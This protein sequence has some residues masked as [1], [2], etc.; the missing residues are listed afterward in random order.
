MPLLFAINAEQLAAAALIVAGLA[1]LVL[2]QFFRSSKSDA[3]GDAQPETRGAAP[4]EPKSPELSREVQWERVAGVLSGAIDGV[5]R[6]QDYHASASQQL[7]AAHYAVQNLVAEL[8]GTM[9][10]DRLKAAAEPAKTKPVASQAP[11]AGAQ[12]AAARS[13]KAA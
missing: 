3:Q 12:S 8:A 4:L 13:Q 7:D 1:M 6:T 9:P 11:E 5:K 2:G 10:V